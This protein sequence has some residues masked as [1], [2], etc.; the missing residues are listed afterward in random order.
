MKN[1]L[2]KDGFWQQAFKVSFLCAMGYIPAGIAFACCLW[3]QNFL[4]MAAI[5]SSV[6]LYAVRR[7]MLLLRC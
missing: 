6:V 4:Y 7:N 1:E 5:L 3:Q 2:I